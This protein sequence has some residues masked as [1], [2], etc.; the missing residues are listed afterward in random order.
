MFSVASGEKDIIKS[1]ITVLIVSLLGILILVFY[2]DDVP[3][4]EMGLSISAQVYNPND[5][6]VVK[7]EAHKQEQPQQALH[8]LT[9]E[10]SNIDKNSIIP[11]I[12]IPAIQPDFISKHD[13]KEIETTINPELMGDLLDG[14]ALPAITVDHIKRNAEIIKSG[15]V[16]ADCMPRYTDSCESYFPEI[17]EEQN[18]DWKEEMDEVLSYLISEYI[19]DKNID[20]MKVIC[21]QL[22]CEVLI[23]FNANGELTVPIENMHSEWSRLVA[24]LIGSDYLNLVDIDL[25]IKPH[26]ISSDRANN[27]YFQYFYLVFKE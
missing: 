3:I 1:L 7:S 12:Q 17:S 26:G 16:P 18:Q 9:I 20:L 23:A 14:L 4:N 8:K 2:E 25:G 13:Q 24:Y 21:N 27:V 22:I 15:K 6:Q 19:K 5:A 11:S 10:P